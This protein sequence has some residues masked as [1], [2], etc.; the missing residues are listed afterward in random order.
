MRTISTTEPARGSGRRGRLDAGRA[1]TALC[2]IAIL[3]FARSTLLSTAIA[4]ELVAAAFWLWARATPDAA[5]Q[6]PRW[7]WVRRP[8]TALWVAVGVHAIAPAGLHGL[9]ATGTVRALQWLEAV[10]VVWAGLELL[11]ALPIARPYSDLPGPVLAIR[12]WLPVLLPAT[13]FVVLWGQAPHW[14]GVVP[15]RN[16]ALALLLVTSVLAALRGFSRRSWTASL[17]WLAIADSAL[18]AMLVAWRILPPREVFLLWLCASGAHAFLLAGELRGSMPRRGPFSARL[19][20]AA[21]WIAVASLSFPVLLAAGKAHGPWGLLLRIGLAFAVLLA[22]WISVR[23]LEVMPERRRMVRWNT[24]VA[25]SQIGAIVVAG[26]GPATLSLAFAS[27]AGI[28]FGWRE[29]LLA[30]GPAVV[31]GSGAVLARGRLAAPLAGLSQWLGGVMP[32]IAG[33]AF[34]FVIATERR[35]VAL[36]AVVLRG[37]T[38]SLH[39]LHTGDAQEYLLFLVGISVLALVLPLLQ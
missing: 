19:W 10:C 23:R 1:G 5:A 14:S 32:L 26:S 34:R 2:L 18:A 24:L 31:G 4:L 3:L 22:T 33:A 16:A 27:G 29:A 9:S 17:R 8:A 30:L 28:S 38:A 35:L 25:A 39:E 12:P 37:L 6:V 7:S 20:R 21:S 36:G 11:A 15:V 13:G